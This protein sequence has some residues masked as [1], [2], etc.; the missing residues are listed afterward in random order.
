M[1]DDE[2]GRREVG[3]Q[4]RGQA[5]ERLH[6]AGRGADDHDVVVGHDKAP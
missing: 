4:R 6:A 5:D 3:R 2:H 1:Q